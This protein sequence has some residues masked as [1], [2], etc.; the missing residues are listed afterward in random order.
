MTT[1]VLL[2]GLA[3]ESGHWGGFVPLLRERWPRDHIVTLDLPGNGR[4]NALTSPL[5]I[6]ATAAWCRE[7]LAAAGTP[8]PYRLLALSMG[9]MV[10]VEWA[11]QAPAEVDACVLISTSLA[12]VSPWFRRLRPASYAA[13]IGALLGI[14]SARRRERAILRLT[15]AMPLAHA[16]VLEGWVRLRRER[17]VTTANALRQLVAAARYRARPAAPTAPMLLLA[18]AADALVAAQCSHDLAR[19]DCSAS[20]PVRARRARWSG[21]SK[22]E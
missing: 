12:R 18:G 1:W 13:L 16:G 4:A 22:P 9:A 17:P 7:R 15:S 14:G 8:P 19:I 5:T 11:A 20:L 10:A 2:R 6:E 21:A 3:R